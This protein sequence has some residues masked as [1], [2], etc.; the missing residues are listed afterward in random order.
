MTP[1][2]EVLNFFDLTTRAPLTGRSVVLVRRVSNADLTWQARCV[3]GGTQQVSELHSWY[4]PQPAED[5]PWVTVPSVQQAFWFPESA[6][7]RGWPAAA[8]PRFQIGNRVDPRF[9]VTPNRSDMTA[10][11]LFVR[12]FGS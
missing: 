9:L 11:R 1:G 5:G 12:R 10:R 4:I 2:Y 7:L 3:H 8:D 6:F